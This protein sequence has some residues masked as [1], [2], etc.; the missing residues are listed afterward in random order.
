MGKR[1]KHVS[2]MTWVHTIMAIAVIC[3]LVI[4]FA[5]GLEPDQPKTMPKQPVRKQPLLDSLWTNPA[6]TGPPNLIR[7][8]NSCNP[9]VNGDY[10][11]FNKTQTTWGIGNAVTAAAENKIYE[12]SGRCYQKLSTTR[13]LSRDSPTVFLSRVL[14]SEG[15]WIVISGTPRKAFYAATTTDSASPPLSRSQDSNNPWKWSWSNGFD[16]DG[17]NSIQVSVIG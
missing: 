16:F 11:V 13:T 7:I 8:S 14:Y 9:D 17:G 5:P 4:L 1:R 2:N 15:K 3:A 12:H 10:K 6:K